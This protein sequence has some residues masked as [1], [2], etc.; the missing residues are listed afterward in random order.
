MKKKSTLTDYAISFFITTACITILE[1]ILGLVFFPNMR[2]GY[3]AFLSPP[4]FGFLTTATALVNYS[5]IELSVKQ[6][7]F[8]RFL[9]LLLIEVIVFG[10]NFLAGSEYELRLNIVLAIGIAL[11][12]CTVYLVIWLNDRRFANHFNEKLR[13]FQEAN[14]KTIS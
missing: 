8:R 6:V 5:R 2:F 11:I 9:Q 13:V 10:L 12:F 3:E 14:K 4:L 7:L 1:G